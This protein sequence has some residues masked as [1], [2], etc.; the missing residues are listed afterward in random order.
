MI[1]T[2]QTRQQFKDYI[3]RSLGH[4]VIE[5]NIDQDQMEDRIDEAL[6]FF[7][8]RV[9]DGEEKTYYKIQITDQMKID[10]YITLP[11]NINGVVKIF[12]L[13]STFG[14]GDLFN[15]QYQI[16]MSEVWNFSSQSM[17][18]Y[19]MT[20]QHLT[21]LQEILVG[22]VPIRYN[23]FNQRLYLDMDWN[24]RETGTFLIAE[25]YQVIDPAEFANAWNDRWLIKYAS[26]LFKRQWG[27]N[28]SKYENIKMPGG[29]TFSGRRMLD[30]AND[31]IRELEQKL[32]SSYQLFPLDEIY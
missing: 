1:T 32:I 20:Q 10:K 25:C 22:S 13:S 17:V 23:R 21:M 12:N 18:P 30:D 19:Y 15:I 16:L 3:M 29:V 24:L 5:L 4:P 11:D 8:D 6:K 9:Y 7:W 31:E 2:I 14:G 27:I 26:A 28:T